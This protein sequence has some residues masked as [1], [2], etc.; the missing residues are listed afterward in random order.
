M[1]TTF[2]KFFVGQ[3]V[4][5]TFR[6]QVHEVEVVSISHYN[7]CWRYAVYVPGV[8]RRVL[9]EQRLRVPTRET[10]LCYH[11][12]PPVRQRLAIMTLCEAVTNLRA[13]VRMGMPH[14]FGAGGLELRSQ[15][16]NLFIP[17]LDG[18]S[19]QTPESLENLALH[20]E[21]VMQC[22][23]TGPLV[24]FYDLPAGVIAQIQAG[25]GRSHAFN[26]LLI[27]AIQTSLATNNIRG[28]TEFV[29][30]YPAG[31][32]LLRISSN[33]LLDSFEQMHISELD[34]RLT[35][36]FRRLPVP[37]FWRLYV[38][39]RNELTFVLRAFQV[40]DTINDDIGPID[41][42]RIVNHP[43][44]AGFDFTLPKEEIEAI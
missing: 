30:D 42:M 38:D 1:P 29:F 6:G 44:L 15:N 27:Q 21:A 40:K 23:V 25:F 36:H 18:L 9:D 26:T 4:Q 12:M 32:D 22:M 19:F 41:A 2:N 39:D 8:G 14:K 24:L 5:I 7:G 43:S 20:L 28:S 33:I 16:G 31:N 11:E 34:R 35:D 3:R 17:S 37:E 13:M 10:V